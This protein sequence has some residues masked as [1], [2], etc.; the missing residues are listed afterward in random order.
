MKRTARAT[1]SKDLQNGEGYLSTASGVLREARYSFRTRFEQEPGTNPEE[2]IA[3][4]HAGCFSMALT[5]FLGNAGLHPERVDTSAELEM[6][7]MGRSITGI[8][9]TVV[10]RVPD[11]SE[12]D[13]QRL[14]EEAKSGCLVSRV[15]RVPV[16]LDARLAP[17]G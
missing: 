13:F 7:G 14:A 2:L 12:A 16:T 4:A 8:R 17:G 1:W 3:A 9:L 10:A 15:L 11:A 6:E 5:Y